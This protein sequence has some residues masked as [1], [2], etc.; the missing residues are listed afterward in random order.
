MGGRTYGI[1]S[2]A[3]AINSFDIYDLTVDLPRLTI[4]SSGNVG[5]GTSSP[6]YLLTVNGAACDSDGALSSCSSDERLKENIKPIENGLDLIMKLEP[7]SFNFIGKNTTQ[8]GLIAQDVQKI[9]P[10]WITSSDT[11]GYMSWND[12]GFIQWSTVKAIQELK[13]EN[14][15]LKSEVEMLKQELCKKDSSYSWCLGIKTN[16]LLCSV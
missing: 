15:N 11:P 5:I 16:L 4:D 9:N 14:D 12:N 3:S 8:A 6:N 10:D 7:K 1:Y 2:G 13:T